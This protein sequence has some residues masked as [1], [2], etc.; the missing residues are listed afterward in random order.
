MD[1]SNLTFSLKDVITIIVGLGSL[2]GFYFALKRDIEKVSS[3][4]KEQERKQDSEHQL[5]IKA[6]E[7]TQL[8]TEKKEEA[9][10]KRID[11]I[12]EEHKTAHSKLEVK[13]D[14]MSQQLTVLNAALAEL[15]GYL[16]GKDK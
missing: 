15:T 8:E 4:L 5:V 7:E 1:I 6:L 3:D 11:E 16:K 10:N 9:L 13:I 2:F 12:K 14:N